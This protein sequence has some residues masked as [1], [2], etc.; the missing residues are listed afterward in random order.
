MK[1]FELDS[2]RTVQEGEIGSLE[3][4]VFAPVSSYFYIQ[5]QLK[6]LPIVSVSDPNQCELVSVEVIYALDKGLGMKLSSPSCPILK[7][8]ISWY[9]YSCIVH[10]CSLMSPFLVST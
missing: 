10:L 2:G 7:G 4:H 1:D 8:Q 9:V 3:G 6:P 5:I